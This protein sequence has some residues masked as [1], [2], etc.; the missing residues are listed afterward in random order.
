MASSRVRFIPLE[1]VQEI[2]SI[3]RSQ[4]YALVRSGDLRAIQVGGRGQWRVEL[5]ELE[6]YIERAYQAAAKAISND[7]VTD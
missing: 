3:S 2:L 1:H 4:A 7:T 5:T 6:A